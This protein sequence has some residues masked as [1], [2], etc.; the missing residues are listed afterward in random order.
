MQMSITRYLKNALLQAGKVFLLLPLFFLSSSCMR[1]NMLLHKLEKEDADRNISQAGSDEMAF[2]ASY[3][4]FDPSFNNTWSSP[5]EGFPLRASVSMKKYINDYID[6]GW[7][8]GATINYQ[9]FV[10]FRPL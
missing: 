2:C 3:G 6:I 8:D 9:V 10:L 7:E 1:N 4:G 5:G